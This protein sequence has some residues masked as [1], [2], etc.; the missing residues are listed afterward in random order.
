MLIIGASRVAGVIA[1][2]LNERGVT[3]VI[4]TSNHEQEKAAG[5]EG[6]TVDRGDPAVVDVL[7]VGFESHAKGGE[8]AIAMFVLS[9]DE[10]H[11][12]TA[13]DE[14]KPDPGD[15]L[16]GLATPPS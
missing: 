5:D 15:E 9:P 2:T 13:D 8:W 16:I 12:L 11:V 6:L 10:L 3:A 1:R 7:K 4:W 14:P